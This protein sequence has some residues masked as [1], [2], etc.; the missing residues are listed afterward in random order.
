MWGG[1]LPFWSFYIV[2]NCR[3][4]IGQTIWHVLEGHVYGIRTLSDRVQYIEALH[5]LLMFPLNFHPPALFS[6][7]WLVSHEWIFPLITY[8]S[9]LCRSL[10]RSTVSN[11]LEKSKKAMST[12]C[13]LS[14][15]CRKLLIIV[16]IWVSQE[17]P[18]LK[19]WFK[20]VRILFFSRCFRRCLQ[21][22]CSSILQVTE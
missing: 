22:M 21:I 4:I 16:I 20:F 9:S 18:D 10:S 8:C 12:C 3:Q 13:P 17:Y 1:L 6:L 5:S 7:F 19:P 11:A 14:C 2:G 15:S